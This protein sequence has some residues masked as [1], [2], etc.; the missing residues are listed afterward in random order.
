MGSSSPET[1]HVVEAPKGSIAVLL[2]CA[3]ADA[4]ALAER[5]DQIDSVDVRLV[6]G[7]ERDTIALRDE[8]AAMT[9]QSLVVICKSDNLG[10]EAV[11]RAV[12]CFGLR[13][14]WTHRL[15]VLEMPPRHGSAWVASVHRTLAAMARRRTRPTSP[16]IATVRGEIRGGVR[17]IA[18]PPAADAPAVVL[19]TT[20]APDVRRDDVGPIPAHVRPAG[21]RASHLALV[22]PIADDSDDAVASISDACLLPPAAPTTPAPAKAKSR[23]ALP[24]AVAAIL[25]AA[26]VGTFA[27]T[28]P[29][30]PTPPSTDT[31]T[32]EVATTRGDQDRFAPI[33]SELAPM[34]GLPQT[35]ARAAT[36]ESP[37]DE[38]RTLVVVHTP[39]DRFEDALADGRAIR[40][41]GMLVWTEAL[42]ADNWW[43]A[44][45]LCRARALAGLRGWRLPTRRRRRRP[46]RSPREA[47]RRR[48]RSLRAQGLDRETVTLPEPV[49]AFPGG[50]ER[51][52]AEYRSPNGS[53]R[54]GGSLTAPPRTRRLCC[55]ATPPQSPR[56]R[57]PDRVS[58]RAR[59]RFD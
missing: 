21:K 7:L 20:P 57:S 2:C 45:N 56:L 47:A 32:R 59:S 33:A 48:A 37:A 36:P 55:H 1:L 58:D 15:L 6:T 22:M 24:G 46:L 14:T 41:D 9:T 28:R 8:L 31:P 13:R 43:R 19:A 27:F 18:T 26:I 35:H 49:P 4:D 11:R 54:S 30:D 17:E 40:H 52:C 3:E 16:E 51:A 34:P 44:A 38:S 42:P 53:T 10:P 5:M 29:A 25:T 12:E 39:D 23:V 50:R